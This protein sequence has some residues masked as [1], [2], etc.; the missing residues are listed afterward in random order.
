MSDDNKNNSSSKKCPILHH[1][2]R[3]GALSNRKF[4]LSFFFLKKKAFTIHSL[5]NLCWFLR[6]QIT[7]DWWPDSLNV[8]MLSRR[9]PLP[10]YARA[11]AEL[12]LA[13]VK[14][15]IATL[16]TDSQEWWPADW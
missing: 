9:S 5:Q 8:A 1:P 16:M 14:S 13:Q 3:A 2:T 11:F 12:D 10:G 6:I 4:N 7:G 15:D